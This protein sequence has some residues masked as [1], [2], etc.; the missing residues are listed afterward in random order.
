VALA[1]DG[2]PAGV[3]ATVAPIPKGQAQAAIALAGG[4]SLA[5]GDYAFRVIGSATFQNQPKQVVLGNAMLRVVKP[6]EVTA[7]PAGPVHRGAA[8]KLKLS[9]VRAPAVGGPITV[10]LKNLPVGVSAPAEITIPDG[11]NEVTIDLTAAAD[12]RLGEAGITAVATAKI[13]EK[14]VAVESLPAALR[15]AMP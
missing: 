8:Q 9:V 5:E 7:A 12:A 13:K 15:V 6:I 1:V 14:L 4:G 11:Q 3:T 2:L 10:R